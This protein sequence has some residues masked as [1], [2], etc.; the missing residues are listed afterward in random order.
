MIDKISPRLVW[1]LGANTGVFSRISSQKGIQTIAFDIDSI[2]VEKNYLECKKNKEEN[3]LPLLLD[4]TNPS[5]FLGWESLERMSFVKRGPADLVLALALIH[6]LAISNNVPLDRLAI[7]FNNI[8]KNLIIEFIPKDDSQIKR[9]LST[10]EDIFDDYTQ[11]NF[12]LEFSK[13]FII[14]ESVK[15][16]DSHRVI[17][18][19]QVKEN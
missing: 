16:P 6:H 13:L 17:Y 14:K 8:C 10:R 9:L 3:L 11:E 1:D 5:P 2:A 19:M 4:L 15:N 18:Y 7:F 12:E